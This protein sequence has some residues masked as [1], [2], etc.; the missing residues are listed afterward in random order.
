[1]PLDKNGQNPL[2]TAAGT[3]STAVVELLIPHSKK[4]DEADSAGQTSLM[5]AAAGDHLD[6]SRLLLK[7][8]AKINAIDHKKTTALASAILENRIS[9]ARFLLENGAVI[10]A[11]DLSHL[12]ITSARLFHD[13]HIT[14]DDYAFLIAHLSGLITE[15]DV[16]DPQGVPALHWIAASNNSAALE[17]FLKRSPDLDAR[18]PDGR[19]ALMWAV[20]SHAEKTA[21][22]LTTAGADPALMDKVGKTAADW[23]KWPEVVPVPDN[24]ST[25]IFTRNEETALLA[26]LKA[27][28]WKIEDRIGAY[29]PLHLAAALGNSDA[30]EKILKLGAPVDQ[31]LYDRSTPLMEAAANGR[32]PIMEI[33]LSKGADIS[34]KN[35]SGNRA[36]DLAVSM[37]HPDAARLLLACDGAMVKNEAGLLY[38][39]VNGG[40]PALLRDFLKAGASVPPQP[41]KPD[42]P[43]LPG[44]RIGRDAPVISAASR[45]DPEML[46]VLAE[47]PA[48]SA[49]DDPEVLSSALHEAAENGRLDNVRYM[50]EFLKADPNL[51]TDDSMGGITRIDSKKNPKLVTGFTPLSRALEQD[52]EEIVRYLIEKKA[53]ITGRTRSGGPPLNFVAENR[54]HDLMKFFLEH[55]AATDFVDFDGKTALH[56]AAEKNDDVAVGLLLSHGADKN[57]TTKKGETPL[58]L[59]K[60]AKA[61]KTIPLLDKSQ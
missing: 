38:S 49:L 3:G 9:T 44:R 13:A 22:I 45:K 52:H 7:A 11:S 58:Y 54:D 20:V 33:L 19:T 15:T 28:E 46:R 5:L 55:A 8:G 4:V 41:K 23:E 30:A 53:M 18:S 27:G 21:D 17:D 36:I 57:A 24:D 59:A 34:L 35:G 26:Y 16:R 40:D 31:L 56:I 61:E 51:Q 47:F 32:I 37:G 10:A 50:I 39:L 6:S 42:D 29:A 25:Q 43:F 60:E 12:L 14:P 1:M 2:Q 48:A